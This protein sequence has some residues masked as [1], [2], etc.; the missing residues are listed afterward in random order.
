MIEGGKVYL[1]SQVQFLAI[2][3]QWYC[4]FYCVRSSTSPFF[5]PDVQHDDRGGEGVR[6]EPGA[7]PG[8]YP[9]TIVMSF[10][11][12]DVQHDYRG[13]EGVRGEPGAVP[14]YP[15]TI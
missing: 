12:A 6:G 10:F 5:S 13:G 14:G 1:G 8:G 9:S 4:P 3:Q 2:P 15:S 7:V 11:S